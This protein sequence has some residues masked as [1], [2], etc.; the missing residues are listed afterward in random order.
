MSHSMATSTAA[1][2]MTEN[3]EPQHGYKH[4]SIDGKPQWRAEQSG[5]VCSSFAVTMTPSMFVC[6]IQLH[7]IIHTIL[8]TTLYS[9]CARRHIVMLCA[10]PLSCT[11]AAF[12]WLAVGRTPFFAGWRS[13]FA[14][15]LYRPWW[16]WMVLIWASK[17]TQDCC[18]Y[19]GPLS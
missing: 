4:C 18:I 10:L 13:L 2:L 5:C 9:S 15:H 1:A 7:I 3:N 8:A 11:S 16:R 19:F 17:I 12:L 6:I 14:T